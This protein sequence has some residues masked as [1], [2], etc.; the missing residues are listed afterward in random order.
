MY[1]V[2]IQAIGALKNKL[3]SPTIIRWL[4]KNGLTHLNAVCRQAALESF[5]FQLNFLDANYR[6]AMLWITVPFCV[7]RNLAVKNASNLIM[8]KVP[9]GLMKLQLANVAQTSDDHIQSLQY[10][11]FVWFDK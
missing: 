10:S 3:L 2:S 11:L 6:Q 9:F 8:K 5:S 4:I 7:D 1:A